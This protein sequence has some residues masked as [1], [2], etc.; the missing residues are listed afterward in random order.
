[1]DRLPPDGQAFWAERIVKAEA[2][3]FQPNLRILASTTEHLLPR[4]RDVCQFPGW[5]RTLI[6]FARPDWLICSR[7]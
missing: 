6:S 5:G 2:S 7:P 3:S 4:L 1:M